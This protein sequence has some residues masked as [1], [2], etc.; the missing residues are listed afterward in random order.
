MYKAAPLNGWRNG[1][2]RGVIVH[3]DPA[4]AASQ[5]VTAVS[6]YGRKVARADR[7]CHRQYPDVHVDTAPVELEL[8]RPAA[9]ERGSI[10]GDA[11]AWSI[12]DGGACSASAVPPTP[13]DGGEVWGLLTATALSGP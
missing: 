6:F 3:N 10:S 13:S 9:Y 1:S 5:A 4:A 7:P 2:A 8:P 12:I 11:A